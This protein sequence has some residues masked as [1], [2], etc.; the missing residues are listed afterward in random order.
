MLIHRTHAKALQFKSALVT[1]MSDSGTRLTR[2]WFI[3]SGR[4]RQEPWSVY[5]LEDNMETT[6]PSFQETDCG[7]A[8][9]YR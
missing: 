9:L 3:E 7:L 1:T 4:L 8:L 6:G 2:A 5:I